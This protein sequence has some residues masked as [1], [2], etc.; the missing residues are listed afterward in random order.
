M[1]ASVEALECLST[2]LE[3]PPL[4][5]I[6][7]LGGCGCSVTPWGGGAADVGRCGKLLACKDDLLAEASVA[8]EGCDK[9]LVTING[10]IDG[11]ELIV[12]SLAWYSCL[13]LAGDRMTDVGYKG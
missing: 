10:D 7:V 1:C 3:T 8:T 4:C 13:F 5:E 2:L 6:C 11:T 9:L 12:A